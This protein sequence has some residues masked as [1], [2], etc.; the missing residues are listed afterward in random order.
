MS[1]ET[2][3]RYSVP[4]DKRHEGWAVFLLDSSGMLAV[5]SDYGNYAYH[6]HRGWGDYD[7]RKFLSGIDQYYL[8]SKLSYGLSKEVR[9][10][11]TE[12]AIREHIAEMLKS[13]AFTSADARREANRLKHAD[14]DSEIG[15]NDWIAETAIVDAHELIRRGP[16]LQLVALAE[17]VWPRLVELLKRDLLREAEEKAECWW[18]TEDVMLT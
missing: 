16:P 1:D 12:K 10:K 15:I 13:E 8:T 2:V 14:F 5:C 3:W 18:E 9:V 11:E 6:W 7:F 4:N 17:R